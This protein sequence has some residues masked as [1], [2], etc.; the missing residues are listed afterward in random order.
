MFFSQSRSGPTEYAEFMGKS[1]IL[2]LGSFVNRAGVTFSCRFGENHAPEARV[3]ALL[4]DLEILPLK[5]VS[6]FGE[7][8]GCASSSRHIPIPP[9]E[10]VLLPLCHRQFDCGSHSCFR[11]GSPAISSTFCTRGLGLP[12]FGG[13]ET[14][15]GRGDARKFSQGSSTQAPPC[16]PSFSFCLVE[17][18]L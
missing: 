2:V 8:L 9:H 10:M 5:G 16:T 14:L 17:R 12:S 7:S 11:Q 18:C 15:L 13:A 3:Q 1:L 6:E 4:G